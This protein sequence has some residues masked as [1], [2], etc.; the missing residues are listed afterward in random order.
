MCLQVTALYLNMQFKWFSEIFLQVVDIWP[1][2]LPWCLQFGWN[3]LKV[4]DTFGT[5][6]IFT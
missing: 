6:N 4:E 2:I 3:E 1:L 5:E